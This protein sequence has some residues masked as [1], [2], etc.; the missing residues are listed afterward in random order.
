MTDLQ[1]PYQLR[2]V[3]KPSIVSSV[4]G[5]VLGC[6]VAALACYAVFSKEVPNLE[7]YTN[8]FI[9]TTPGL[10]SIIAFINNSEMLAAVAVFLVWFAVGILGYALF[11][12]VISSIRSN[13]AFEREIIKMHTIKDRLLLLSQGTQKALV[14]LL[15]TLLAATT[16]WIAAVGMLPF[17]TTMIHGAVLYSAVS[18]ILLIVACLCCTAIVAHLFT[19]AF[20]MITYHTNQ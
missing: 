7:Q 20:R 1:E 4:V 8:L 6:L 14:R 3:L 19:I 15:G 13:V 11:S 16:F 9:H 2:D 5:G 18:M 10:T 12:I 17:L